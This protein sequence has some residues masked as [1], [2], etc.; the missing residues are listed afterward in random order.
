M[1]ALLWT[2]IPP[3][4]S[5]LAIPLLFSAFLVHSCVSPV[6]VYLHLLLDSIL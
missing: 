5:A 2:G 6:F 1:V 3:R 4:E